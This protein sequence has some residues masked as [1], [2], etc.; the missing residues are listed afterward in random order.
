MF[1]S[2]QPQDRKFYPAMA[3][4]IA[5]LVFAGFTPSFYARDWSG[6][7]TPLAG[8]VLVHGVAGTLFVLVLTVQSWLIAAGR[9]S[10]H[11]TLGSWGALLAMAFVL[12][13][14]V[15]TFNLEQGHV[16][17]SRRVLAAHVWTNA[18]PLAA[19][20]LLVAAGI[21]QRHVPARH[22]RLMLLAA[23]VL[24]PPA[25]GRLFGPFDLAWLNLPLYVCAAA[26]NAVYDVIAR[27]RPHPFSV[28]PAAALVAIDVTTTSW[29]AAVGS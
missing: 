10:W 19:F 26:A 8:P 11:R 23:V 29:L 4:V 22:K 24:L 1:E 25:T 13:G 18:A 27:G 14:I 12:S 7:A 17:E 16:G 2:A 3:T 9:E 5:A 20:A 6:G 15:V 21:W 28:L